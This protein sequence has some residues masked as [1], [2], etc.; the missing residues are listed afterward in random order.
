MKKSYFSLFLIILV[1]FE[2]A[3]GAP[4]TVSLD[5]FLKR[6][7][8]QSPEAKIEMAMRDE[9]NSRSQGV[10]LPPPMIGVMNMK[11]AGGTNKGIEISQE[12][13]FPTRIGK[14]KEVR[15]LEAKTQQL[16]Y[17]YR[18]SEI[19]LDARLAYFNFWKAYQIKKILEE[20]QSWLKKHVKIS[21]TTAR[22]D[23][24]GQIHLLGTESEAD[25]L[26]NDALEAQSELIER[27]YALKNFV[28]DLATEQLLPETEPKLEAFVVDQKAKSLS[29][30]A[31]EAEVQFTESLVSLKKQSYFPDI[32]IRYRAFE[33]NMM[34]PRNEEIM[35][36]INLPFLFFW[37]PKSEVS[38]ASAR[39]LRAKAELEKAQISIESRLAALNARS[40]ALRKQVVTLKDKLL[41]RAHKRMKLVEN[42]SARTMEGLDE[43]RMVML[44]YLDLRSKEVTARMEYEKTIA[45]ILKLVSKE[46]EL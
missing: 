33:G 34:T 32:V 7:H 14:E 15:N 16:L 1:Q 23:S 45:E 36:G 29:I 35:V 8:S 30:E 4:N 10:R 21:R 26:E 25:L 24:S 46:A 5:E 11:D 44:D 37:Q 20:K 13:P 6:V 28:P 27:T 12:F 2:N 18:K 38:E 3:F 42:L 39:H 22:S 31:R 17:A 40:E 41:P 43:H 19:L 9:A